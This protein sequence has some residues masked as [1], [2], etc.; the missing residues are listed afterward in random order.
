MS[1]DLID[2]VKFSQEEQLESL[3]QRRLGNRI[4]GLRIQ[5]QPRGVVI[6]GRTSTYHAKQLAQHAAMELANMPILAN[7]IEVY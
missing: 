7:D 2:D 6:Q 3:M 5:L 1:L 4:R